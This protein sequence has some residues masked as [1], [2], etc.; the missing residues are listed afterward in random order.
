MLIE[1]VF[2]AVLLSQATAPSQAGAEPGSAVRNVRDLPWL[3]MP[4]VEYP[5]RALSQGVGRGVAVL[6]CSVAAE[7]ALADCRIV[8]ESPA[9]MGFGQAALAGAR[10][11]RLDSARWSEPGVTFRIGFAGVDLS[12]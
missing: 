5:E 7:G 8:D 4:P 6:A 12:N 1:T 3:R 10:R 11:A 9:G 2:A